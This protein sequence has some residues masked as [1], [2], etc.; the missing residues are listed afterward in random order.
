MPA[1]VSPPFLSVLH[2]DL[3]MIC[4]SSGVLK[5]MNCLT[6]AFSTGIAV[7]NKKKTEKL[8]ETLGKTICAAEILEVFGLIRLRGMEVGPMRVKLGSKA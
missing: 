2:A 3:E 5:L 4:L 6:A 8:K 1:A 7:W